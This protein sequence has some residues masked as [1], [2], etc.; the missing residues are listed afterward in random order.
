MQPATLARRAFLIGGDFQT[1]DPIFLDAALCW[2]DTPQEVT[3][4]DTKRLLNFYLEFR[5]CLFQ[6]PHGE[7]R[8]EISQILSTR[9]EVLTRPH[10]TLPPHREVPPGEEAQDVKPKHTD[11]SAGFAGI[12]T[13]EF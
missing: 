13:R 12:E 7:F 5:G 3:Y 6:A 8:K 2:F 1:S 10:V 4:G 11:R 9:L